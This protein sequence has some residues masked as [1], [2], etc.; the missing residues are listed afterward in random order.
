MS[1][2]FPKPEQSV[3]APL[4]VENDE[5]DVSSGLPG[6]SYP[7]PHASASSKASLLS[8]F[9]TRPA[10]MGAIVVTALLLFL[11]VASY[12]SALDSDDGE[13]RWK[14]NVCNVSLGLSHNDDLK[15][16]YLFVFSDQD[17]ENKYSR[18]LDRVQDVQ[19]SR[20]WT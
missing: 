4:N 1:R 17:N 16:R 12:R 14:D 7:P 19:P 18:P 15:H 20:H 11:A 8:L 6:G 3:Y 10:R 13:Y 2:F 9:R 5:E